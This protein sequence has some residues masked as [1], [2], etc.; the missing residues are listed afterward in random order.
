MVQDDIY[1]LNP[2]FN[3]KYHLLQTLQRYRRIHK[4]LRKLTTD[5]N[6]INDSLKFVWDYFITL[7]FSKGEGYKH[8]SSHLVNG[9]INIKVCLIIRDIPCLCF[10]HPNRMFLIITSDS[11]TFISIWR[12]YHSHGFTSKDWFKPIKLFLFPQVIFH[13]NLNYNIIKRDS[14]PNN[15]FPLTFN[16]G[17][18]IFRGC[19]APTMVFKSPPPPPNIDFVLYFSCNTLN[20]IIF[21]THI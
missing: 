8:K 3:L 17:E 16:E 4:S 10:N 6:R 12:N 21:K 5:T 13:E 18:N 14:L 2:L 19:N 1:M 15:P 20:F 9:G 11:I 7:L